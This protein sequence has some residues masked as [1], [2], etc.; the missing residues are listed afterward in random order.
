MFIEMNVK[1][2]VEF[3]SFLSLSLSLTAR[4]KQSIGP[5]SALFTERRAD[6]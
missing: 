2:A 4:N 6:C 3:E 1:S 5:H